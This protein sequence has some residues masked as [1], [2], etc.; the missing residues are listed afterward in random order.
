MADQRRNSI[1]F[2]FNEIKFENR[3][4]NPIMNI[5][6]PKALDCIDEYSYH[7]GSSLESDSEKESIK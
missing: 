7:S 2:V 4:N 6:S 1:Q 5:A 3:Y